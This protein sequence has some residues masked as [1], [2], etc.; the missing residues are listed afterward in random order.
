LEKAEE[1]YKK[2]SIKKMMEEIKAG[3]KAEMSVMP[4]TRG[5]RTLWRVIK[6]SRGG[7]QPVVENAT[8]W[9]GEDKK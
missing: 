2:N 3:A 1:Q 9:N 7:I 8:L 6:R 4:G 5:Y